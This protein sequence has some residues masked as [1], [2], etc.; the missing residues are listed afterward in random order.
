MSLDALHELGAYIA[1]R[2][3]NPTRWRRH[4]PVR[5]GELTVEI[6]PFAGG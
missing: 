2:G 3:G 1:E 6:V 5:E 4:Q